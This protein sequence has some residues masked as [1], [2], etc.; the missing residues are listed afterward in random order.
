VWIARGHEDAIEAF[1]RGEQLVSTGVAAQPNTR[2]ANPA[3]EPAWKA[4]ILLVDDNAENLLALEAV[5][6]SPD[7]QLVKASSGPRSV[8]VSARRR[9]RG[10][11]A[12]RKDAG[13][14][15]IRNGVVNPRA[16]TLAAHSYPVSDRIQE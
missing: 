14:G 9:F 16:K 6:E 3:A 11:P 15:R 4:K 12:R 2:A 5:L 7:Q 10:D 1:H 13:D 8:A